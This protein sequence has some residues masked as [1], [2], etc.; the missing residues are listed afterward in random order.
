MAKLEFNV[1]SDPTL[2]AMDDIILAEKKKEKKRKYLGASQIGHPCWRKLFYSFRYADEKEISRASDVDDYWR[3]LNRI[4]AAEDG[5]YQELLIIENLRKIPGIE[6]Y[7]DDGTVDE[8]GKPNQIGFSML[9]GHFKGHADGVILSILQAPKTWHVFEV[10]CK[11]EKFF[12]QLE[13]LKAEKGEKEA[14]AEWSEEYFGQAMILM[15]ALQMERHY[16]VCGLPGGR[17]HTSVRTNYNKKIAEAIIEKARVIIFDNWNLPARLSN[18]REYFQCGFCE[19]KELCHDQ[20]FAL[21]HCKTCRYMEPVK[22]GQF[23]CHKKETLITD[24]LL[25]QGCDDHIYNPALI[26]AELIEHQD[27]GCL[28][29]VG[30]YKFANVPATEWPELK[31]ELDG[32]YTSQQL[33]NEIQFI[34]NLKSQEPIKAEPEEQVKAWN[35]K[36]GGK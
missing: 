28:Y 36:S 25:F 34:S 20:K 24:E 4:K 19:Y 6:L 8:N 2:D 9:L 15:H 29:N 18:K 35:K 14:L 16:L 31:G 32:I 21:V 13:K 12:N 7:N 10:K 3:E 17:K 33:R 5:H 1:N 11:L 22:D 23:H 30:N 27:N 26:Q